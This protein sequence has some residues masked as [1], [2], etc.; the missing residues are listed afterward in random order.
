MPIAR[1]DEKPSEKGSIVDITCDS[2]GCL[3]RFVDR[4]DVRSALH[5]H[6]PDN[7]PYYIGFFLVGA[8]QESLASEHNLFG[9]INEVEI[10][11]TS[12]GDWE[13]DKITKGDMIDELLA[14]RNYD[15]K[16]M[17]VSY[18]KQ[19]KASQSEGRVKPAYAAK[20]AKRLKELLSGYPYLVEK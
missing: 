7:S 2:D 19:I 8:Y 9:A 11:L 13:V 10:H 15:L 12:D 18:Q 16:A 6:S 17:V 20:L 5:L 3:E 1:H 4:K 14:A